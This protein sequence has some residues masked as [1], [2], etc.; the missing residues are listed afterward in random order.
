MFAVSR[1]PPCVTAG[2]EDAGGLPEG[3]PLVFELTAEVALLALPVV[4]VK[5]ELEAVVGLEAAE[6]ATVADPVD[7]EVAMPLL[8]EVPEVEAEAEVPARTGA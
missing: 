3:G 7:A 5:V 2:I 4:G 6:P 8:A 1:A